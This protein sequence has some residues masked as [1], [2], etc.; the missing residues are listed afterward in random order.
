AFGFD[1]VG[2]AR[3]GHGERAQAGQLKKVG[4]AGSTVKSDLQASTTTAEA[5]VESCLQKRM[6]GAGAHPFQHLNPDTQKN[7]TR[8]LLQ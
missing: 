6:T 7:L 3:I 4:H 2:I 5:T 8:P 1:R